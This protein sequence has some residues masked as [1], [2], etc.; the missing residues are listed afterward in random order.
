MQERAFTITVQ[1]PDKSQATRKIIAET[2]A[3]AVQ[4]ALSEEVQ[5]T[6]IIAVK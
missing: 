3:D 1:R 2:T 4:I 5:G 6:V